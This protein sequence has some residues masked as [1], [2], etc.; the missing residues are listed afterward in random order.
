MGMTTFDY[1]DQV[2]FFCLCYVTD[3]LNSWEVSPICHFQKSE[4]LTY[5]AYI[6]A[7]LWFRSEDCKL[8]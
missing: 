6:I 4:C 7:F 1:L 3:G 2:H 8:S 5:L